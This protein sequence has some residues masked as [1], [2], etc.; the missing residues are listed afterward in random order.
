VGFNI[1]IAYL[2][3]DRNI[4]D[5]WAVAVSLKITATAETQKESNCDISD[6]RPH[7]Y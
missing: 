2:I 6:L 7:A 3:P 5:E 1:L 4:S